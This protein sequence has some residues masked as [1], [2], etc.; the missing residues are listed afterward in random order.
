MRWWSHHR[1]HLSKGPDSLG[2]R[3]KNT[4][5]Q[6][7]SMQMGL[8]ERGKRWSYMLLIRNYPYCLRHGLPSW[9]WRRNRFLKM[10]SGCCTVE[11]EC[12]SCP[13]FW[14]QSL[15]ICDISKCW[16]ESSE[17][18]SL[19]WVDWSWQL[20][21]SLLSWTRRLQR[22]IQMIYCTLSQTILTLKEKKAQQ[23]YIFL[24]LKDSILI[25][26]RDSTRFLT[27][28]IYTYICIQCNTRTFGWSF[29]LHKRD[30]IIS[31][32]Q[33]S[34]VLTSSPFQLFSSQT[35]L[36]SMKFNFLPHHGNWEE[37]RS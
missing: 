3:S 6:G 8:R 35:L 31:Q 4:E 25:K 22:K 26:W 5:G 14:L 33:R 13:S 20:Y 16:D 9:I 27:C 18:I 36:D 12:C 1:A 34:A 15:P 23:V 21:V 32:C 28:L 30:K 24:L 7:P 37:L 19:Q 2:L 11:E 17:E 10:F 29:L